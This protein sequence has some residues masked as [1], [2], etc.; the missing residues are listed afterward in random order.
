MS[1]VRVTAIGIWPKKKFVLFLTVISGFCTYTGG[2]I[3]RLTKLFF[4]IH[5]SDEMFCEVRSLMTQNVNT[6]QIIIVNN[7]D[8]V[9]SVDISAL[10]LFR[11]NV[12]L[13][14]IELTYRNNECTIVIVYVAC[15]RVHTYSS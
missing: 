11:G 15:T 6:F 2:A 12:S 8:T 4:F 5:S 10:Q 3:I 13:L 1:S 7:F 9:I 14:I